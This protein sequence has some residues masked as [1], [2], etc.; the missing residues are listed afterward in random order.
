MKTFIGEAEPADDITLMVITKK[1]SVVPRY[2]QVENKMDQSPVLRALLHNYG[3]CV[4][5]DKRTLKKMEVALEE[6]VVNVINYSNA[7]HIQ[8]TITHS[9][10]TITITD[11]G[12]PFDPTAQA[13]VDIE[14]SVEKRQIGGLGIALLRQISDEL[15]YRRVE[16]MNQ[17]I[18]I[19]HC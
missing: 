16:D 3:V 17:L 14:K 15:H 12:I 18:I 5:L 19:K 8:L 7:S 13:E 2:I 10:L 9:P 6:A 11:D 4:G 1:T